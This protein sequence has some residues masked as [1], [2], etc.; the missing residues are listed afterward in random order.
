MAELPPRVIPGPVG[1]GLCRKRDD[2][3][4]SESIRTNEC[5]CKYVSTHLQE[6]HFRSPGHLNLY[7]WNGD[8]YQ[9][10]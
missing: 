1:A 9:T 3:K 5:D 2:K 4:Y 6:V 7:H 8:V 10:L